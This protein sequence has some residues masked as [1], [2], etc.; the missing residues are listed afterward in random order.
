M[1]WCAATMMVWTVGCQAPPDDPKGETPTTPTTP[2][3]PITPTTPTLPTFCPPPL[4][5]PIGPPVTEPPVP[6]SYLADESVLAACAEGGYAAMVGEEGFCYIQDALDQ[7]PAGVVVSVCPGTWDTQLFV[8]P[9]QILGAADPAP[10]ATVLYGGD[11]RWLLQV[12]DATVW[13]LTL[14]NGVHA[15]ETWGE[16][17]LSCIVGEDNRGAGGGAIYGSG[18]LEVTASAFARNQ[19]SD[20]GGAIG[21]AAG[22]EWLVVEDTLFLDNLASTLGGGAIGSYTMQGFDWTID[23][24]TFSGNAAP[25]EAGGALV[26][27]SYESR[28]LRINDSTFTR[29][30]AGSAG[31]AVEF[32]GALPSGSPSSLLEIRSSTFE[33][34][35]AGYSGGAVSAVGYGDITTNI[36]DSIFTA[37]VADHAGGAAELG[38][39]DG[40]VNAVT[41]TG[42]VFTANVAAELGGALTAGGYGSCALSLVECSFLDN[43]AGSGGGAIEVSSWYTDVQAS[44]TSTTFE[45]NSVTDVEGGGGA[46]EL[47]TQAATIDVAVGDSTFVANVG[48]TGAIRL[49]KAAQGGTIHLDTSSFVDNVATSIDSGGAALGVAVGMNDE[50]SIVGTSLTMHRNNGYGGAILLQ[51]ACSLACTG[52]DLGTDANDNIPVDATKVDVVFDELGLNFEL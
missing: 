24:S 13:G 10:G 40:T 49:S 31:G 43:E 33:E 7:A 41:I 9:G 1:R 14:R 50:F 37:N 51:R 20:Y 30:F 44:I 32:G 39:L 5:L 42:S 47:S 4:E 29:N 36:T 19:S 16:V 25:S 6:C 15:V 35:H 17:L 27:S 34:N 38:G 21:M 3:T 52:C 45:G 28:S 23:R 12:E 26:A 22:H 2:T 8:R 11:S 18:G 48:G 46:I